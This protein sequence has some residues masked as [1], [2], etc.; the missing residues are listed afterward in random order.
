MRNLKHPL[1]IFMLIMAYIPMNAQNGFLV[2]EKSSVVVFGTST[3]HDWEI[4][5][6]QLSGTAKIELSEAGIAD[7]PSLQFVV[8]VKGMESG[9]GLMNSKTY[10]ALK[11]DEH[12][13]IKYKLSELKD[14]TSNTNGFYT[15]KAIGLLTI[16]GKTQTIS[17]DVMAHV[18]GKEVVFSGEY[19]LDMTTY[20]V[21]P[22][23][24]M[25]GTIKT[26]KDVTIKFKT[27][28]SIN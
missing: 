19:L 1:L 26:G 17:H 18:S 10:D 16:A 8:I 6:E 22:P 2:N 5:C 12:P 13:T 20:D 27:T 11:E 15:M 21:D 14:K 28:Y 25:M 3:I 4:N 9:K 7:I 23:T 24:A